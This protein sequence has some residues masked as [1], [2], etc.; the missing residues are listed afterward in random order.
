MPLL[1]GLDGIKKM[2]K[3]LG[4]YIGITEPPKE[5]FGKIMSISDV[6]ML[7]YY[8]LLSR[9]T[10]EEFNSLKVKKLPQLKIIEDES[11]ISTEGFNSLKDG[12][13]KGKVHPKKAKEDLAMEIVE[14]YWS[15]DEAIKAKEEFEHVFKEK[16]LPEV[17]GTA[18]LTLPSLK[19]SGSGRVNINWLPQIMKDTGLTK[20]TSEAI[21]LIKQGGVKRNGCIVTDTNTMLPLGEHI[22][23]VGKRRFHKVIIK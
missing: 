19:V 15:K 11:H 23:Q 8:E 1:E 14:R 22:I 20:S 5:I 17:I 9:I 10:M 6:L 21:R 4:N 2:S 13:A 16:G 12:I 7:R 18:Y 3:S